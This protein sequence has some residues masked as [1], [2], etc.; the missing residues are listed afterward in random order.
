MDHFKPIKIVGNKWYDSDN[1]YINVCAG[2]YE[3]CGKH[4]YIR[5]FSNLIDAIEAARFNARFDR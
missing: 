2:Y 1:I 4:G 5:S 3:I